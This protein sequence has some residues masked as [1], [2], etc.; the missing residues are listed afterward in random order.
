MP[1]I[2]QAKV[3]QMYI[4]EHA[5]PG[6]RFSVLF[7]LTRDVSAKEI[8][9]LQRALRDDGLEGAT[10]ELGSTAEWANALRLSFSYTKRDVG[11]KV[12]PIA[13]LILAAIGISIPGAIGGWKVG[14]AI[15]KNL[16]PIVLIGGGVIV[17]VA[18]AASKAD[19]RA[20]VSV[21]R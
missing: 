21:R 6:K 8:S 9:A 14:D 3:L 17:L 4:E 1:E 5:Q 18:L 15:S 19:I 11:P 2:D 12:I 10:A 7:H 20:D 13:F 16:I